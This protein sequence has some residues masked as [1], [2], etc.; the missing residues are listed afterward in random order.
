MNGTDRIMRGAINAA[1]TPKGL[2]KGTVRRVFEFARPLRRR[3]MVFLL[4]T[5]VAA[6]LLLITPLLAGHIVDTIVGNGNAT[7]VIW[8]AVTIAV[9]AV[10]SAVIGLA[11]RWQSANI[12]EALIYD[13]RRAVYEHVQRMPVAFFSRTRTGALVSRLN[14]DVIGA[15]KAFTSTLSSVVTNIIQLVLTLAVMMTLSWQ[16]TALSLVLLPIFI[17]PTRKLGRRMAALQREAADHNATMTTQMTERFSAPGATLVKLFGR[18]AVEAD[19]FGRRAGRVRDIGVR[20]AMLTRWFLTSL[21]LVSALA[22]ALVYGVGGYLALSGELAA[23]TIVTLALLLTRLYTPLTQLASVRVDVMTA[24]VSFERVFEVLDLPPMITEKPGA[25]AVPEGDVSVEFDDVRFSYPAASDVSLASLEEVTSFDQH[26]GEEVLHGITFRA[27]PGEMVALVGSSGAGK[28][29]IAGLVPRLYDVD[30][31]AVRLSGVDVRDIRFRSLRSAVGVVTQDGHLFHDTIRANLTYA[32]LGATEPE[33]WDAL[34]RARLA[35]LVRRMPDGLETVVGERGYRLSGGERQRLTIA[36]LLLAQPR[37]VIL[38]EATAH[39]D[40]ASEAA[41]QEALADALTGRT[42]IV[43]AHRLS[44]VRAAD[45]ILVVE[46]GRI[47]ERG[48]HESLLAKNGRYARLHRTQ[49][50]ERVTA[51]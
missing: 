48:T 24:L 21:T 43:I 3:L 1:S 42:A 11:E 30:S 2:R 40:S 19:E 4:L 51:A 16:V 50:A 34:R 25:V 29:T 33:L 46:G 38:D 22:Q 26:G 41:V 17:V 47:A 10:A 7:V 18:P 39:L 32:R 35:D 37:V 15:Q 31:G 8:L 6:V 12:G 36:R 23:G 13:L 20:T 27:R 49:F 9:V 28:S 44:T 14:T 5:V 45:Q